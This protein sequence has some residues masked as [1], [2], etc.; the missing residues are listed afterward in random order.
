MTRSEPFSHRPVMERRDRGRAGSRAPGL[1]VDATVGGGGHSAA[2]LETQPGVRVLGIDRDPDA[3][4]EPRPG[5][6]HRSAGG[7]A[8][9]TPAS[10]RSPSGRAAPA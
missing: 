4:A 6:S 2:L 10:T 7:S 8:S 9:S 1:V 3:L 5:D